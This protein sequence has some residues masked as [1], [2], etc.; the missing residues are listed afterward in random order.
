MKPV[1][2]P[3]FPGVLIDEKASVYLATK[4]GLEELKTSE[5]GIYSR[6]SIPCNGAKRR[7]HVHVLMAMTFLGLTREQTGRGS[8]DLQVDHIDGNKKNNRLENLEVVTKQENLRRAWAA[9]AYAR[10]GHASKGK[11]KPS[12][13]RFNSQQVKEMYELRAS[14]LSY[15]VIAARFHCDHKAVYRILRGETYRQ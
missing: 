10:N 14:G 11:A 5:S 4:D 12:L 15:R 1:S 13:Q 7:M 3:G 9:G 8:G 6:V 2:V